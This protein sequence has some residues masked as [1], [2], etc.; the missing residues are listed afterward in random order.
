MEGGRIVSTGGAEG[1]KVLM[2]AERLV[3]CVRCLGDI[4][5]G[6]YVE[7]VVVVRGG[8]P[9]FRGFG[10]GFTENFDFDVAGSSV[11][12]HRHGW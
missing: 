8:M 10:N 5:T 6:A 12:C 3:A 4:L 9:Y 2:G 1:E 11:Q 7:G